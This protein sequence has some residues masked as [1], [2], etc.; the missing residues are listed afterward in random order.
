MSVLTDLATAARLVLER[1]GTSTVA[2][3]RRGRGS[4]VVLAD[5]LVVTNAHNLR[6][7]TTS[8]T[9]ADGRV[10]QGEV[11]GVDADGDLA[12]LRVPTEGVAPIA[13][14]DADAAAGDVV[15]ALAGSTSGPRAGLRPGE[16]RGPGL[17]GAAG[18]PGP[19]QR[20]ALG[21]AGPRRLRGSGGGRRGS[22]G[23]HQ[24]PSPRGHLP[25]RP[26]RRRAAGPPRA[27]GRRR[28]APAAGARRGRG[29]RRG[30]R[31][32]PSLGRPARPRRPAGAGRRRGLARRP[33]RH[34]S[35]RP[36]GGGGR[37]S[38]HR[39]RRSATPPSTA[40]RAT[41]SPSISSAAPR[42]RR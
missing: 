22:P 20:R 5:G 11:A 18:S 31:P 26:R 28:V 9:F 24:H 6:D 7:R 10:A 23:R 40:W 39:G 3:G 14:A 17:P 15:F 21:P 1:A 16:R 32:P 19:R 8:V 13:W 29:P 30:G 34:P 36:A 27:P 42:S 4:G 41:S 38:P 37:P 25:R 2:I 12:V 35:R 33:G